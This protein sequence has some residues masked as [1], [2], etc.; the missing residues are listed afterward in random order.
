MKTNFRLNLKF[1]P[2][3][4]IPAVLMLVSF[5]P[6]QIQEK[7]QSYEKLSKMKW[8]IGN[9][10]NRSPDGNLRETWQ[11]VNDSVYKGFSCFTRENDTLSVEYVTLEERG[12]ELFY[13]PVVSGQNDGKP[14]TFRLVSS[15][16]DQFV[17]ENPM[18][19]FPQKITYTLISK[20]SMV[21]E[22]SGKTEGQARSEKFP[23][24]RSMKK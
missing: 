11:A 13:I 23:M 2:L 3:L 15:I 18:H 10:E 14:V 16:G 12:N 17:F 5:T 19:D 4:F 22:I 9:W 6:A 7:K 21:A 1:K 8:L 20:D 24:T